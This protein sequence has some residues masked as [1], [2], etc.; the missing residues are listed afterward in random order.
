MSNEAVFIDLDQAVRERDGDP[1]IVLMNGEKLEFPANAPGYLVYGILRYMDDEGDIRLNRI[2]DLWDS[3]IGEAR[4]K[5]LFEK[6]ITWDQLLALQNEL[7]IAWGINRAASEGA[8]EDP[9]E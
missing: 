5:E 7:L 6:G 2:P 3:M 4:L 8:L 9:P 1:I